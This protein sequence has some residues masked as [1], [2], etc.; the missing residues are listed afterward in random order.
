[1]I[2]WGYFS[3]EDEFV[4]IMREVVHAKLIGVFRWSIGE[5]GLAVFEFAGA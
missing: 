1:V 2:D 5:G 4:G 3:V